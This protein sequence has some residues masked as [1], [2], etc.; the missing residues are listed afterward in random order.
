[1][2]NAGDGGE[3]DPPWP[4]LETFKDLHDSGLLLDSFDKHGMFYAEY[5]ILSPEHKKWN[6]PGL[7]VFSTQI[8][9]EDMKTYLIL[10]KYLRAC[11][12]GSTMLT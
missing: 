7:K 5:I 12:L 1:M 10:S 2:L 4:C 11:F 9:V 6:G 3:L 8:T